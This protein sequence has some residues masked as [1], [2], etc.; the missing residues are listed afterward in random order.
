MASVGQKDTGPEIRLRHALHQR[1]F[2]YTLGNRELPGSPDLVFPRLKAVIFVHGCFWH[3]HKCKFG[4]PPSSRK[5]FWIKKLED[6]KIRDKKQIDTLINMN[7]RVLVVW[8]C[9]I[10]RKNDAAFN[11][12]IEKVSQELISKKRLLGVGR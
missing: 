7:W 5:R 9:M 10:K 11:K 8:E 4:K 1:G 3:A 2:R 12:T 6:N